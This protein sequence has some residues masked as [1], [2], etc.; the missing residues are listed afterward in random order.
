MPQV[1][2]QA[3]VA[4]DQQPGLAHDDLGDHDGQDR[5]DRHQVL[6]REVVARHHVGKRHAH[7][8][9]AGGD[10]Q[11]QDQRVAEGLQVL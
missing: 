2:Q 5:Q 9:R 10:R 6:Q 11:A 1:R 3:V 4:Q 8:H 7:Q